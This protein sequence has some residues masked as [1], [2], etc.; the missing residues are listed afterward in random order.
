ML[1]NYVS[2][3][4]FEGLKLL[5]G[6]R[7]VPKPKSVF[8]LHNTAKIELHGLLIT[9]SNCIIPNGRSTVLRMDKDTILKVNGNFSFFYGCDIVLLGGVLELGSGFCNSDT[10]IRCKQSI[11]IGNNVMVSHD[12]TIIDTDAHCMSYKDYEMTKPI[13]I[14]DNVWIG[15]K[16]TILKGVTIGTGS[17]IGAGAVVTKSVPPY[18]LAVGVP[19]KVIKEGIKWR[20]K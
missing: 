8:I 6:G 14:E 19:A 10:K 5:I 15:M 17:M 4:D 7:L 20:K 2:L 9:N 3:K 18:C 1:G 13:V 16:A 11:K 12:V